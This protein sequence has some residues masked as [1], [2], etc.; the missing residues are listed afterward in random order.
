MLYARN[1]FFQEKKAVVIFQEIGYN[2]DNLKCP[3]TL[4]ILNLHLL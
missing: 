3:I 4:V 2:K 1:L